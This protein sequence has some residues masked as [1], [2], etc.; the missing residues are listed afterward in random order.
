MTHRTSQRQDLTCDIDAEARQLYARD[1]KIVLDPNETLSQAFIDA[2]D[3]GLVV[4]DSLG[5]SWYPM[6]ETE[7]TTRATSLASLAQVWIPE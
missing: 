7:I 5:F 1:L 6:N 3:A 4:I 2:E